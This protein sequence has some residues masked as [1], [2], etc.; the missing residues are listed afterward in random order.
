MPKLPASRPKGKRKSKRRTAAIQLAVVAMVVSVFD[1]AIELKD[2]DRSVWLHLDED[3][4]WSRKG[5][6]IAGQTTV[7]FLSGWTARTLPQYI[8]RKPLPLPD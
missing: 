5:P 2:G 8:G 3:V 7:L 4:S 6:P 1:D